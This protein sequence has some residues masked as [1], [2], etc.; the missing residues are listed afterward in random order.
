MAALNM[1]RDV[2][3]YSSAMVLSHYSLNCIT[4]D[5]RYHPVSS[6]MSVNKIYS[7]YQYMV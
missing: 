7:T 5:A 6:M 4:G 3:G 2:L 1:M